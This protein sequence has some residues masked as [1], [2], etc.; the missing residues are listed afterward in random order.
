MP[1]PDRLEKRQWLEGGQRF[2]R[3]RGHQ[4]DGSTVLTATSVPELTVEP[5]GTAWRV[6]SDESG[7]P[8]G[9]SSF[10]LLRPAVSPRPLWFRVVVG[11]F[12]FV[13]ALV[14]CPR[15]WRREHYR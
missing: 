10:T 5:G 15:R 4:R 3:G 7:A 6:I 9:T 8:S 13:S 2:E 1:F 12:H 11:Y 14:V